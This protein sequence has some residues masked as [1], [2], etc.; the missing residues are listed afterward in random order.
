MKNY[1]IYA[2]FFVG[3]TGIVERCVKILNQRRKPTRE[4][5]LS[6]VAEVYNMRPIA[7]SVREN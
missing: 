1:L 5:I 7:F 2:L 6:K 4:E 3:N